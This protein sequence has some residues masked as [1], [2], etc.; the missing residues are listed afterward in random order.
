M[1]H[2]VNFDMPRDV[3]NYIHRIGRTGRAGRSGTHTTLTHTHTHSP[4]TPSD[5]RVGVAI[6]FW[7]KSYD[8]ACAPALAKI[9]AEAGQEV[10]AWLTAWAGKANQHKKDKNWSY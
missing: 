4:L 1:T 5:L 6:T 7:N 8:V 2:V 10:P 3:E 9:A